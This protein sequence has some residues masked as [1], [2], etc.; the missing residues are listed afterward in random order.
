MIERRERH[1]RAEAEDFMANSKIEERLVA[2]ETAVEH[3]EKNMS[4]IKS[5][6]SSGFQD[7]YHKFER[8]SDDNKPHMAI[9]ASWAAVGLI[10][11]S[12]FGSG[13]VRDLSRVEET[14]KANDTRLRNTETLFSRVQTNTRGIDFLDESLKREIDFRYSQ[15]DKRIKELTQ[16]YNKLDDKIDNTTIKAASNST[17]IS[18]PELK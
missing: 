13:Y 18:N 6:I 14:T 11:L 12:M 8:Q 5:S 7:L 4:E 16:Y 10:V 1:R 3:I 9:W 2:V 17:A 15:V